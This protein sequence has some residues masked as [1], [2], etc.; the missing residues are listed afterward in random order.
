MVA[1]GILS[2]SFSFSLILSHTLAYSL[3]LYP[4]GGEFNSTIDNQNQ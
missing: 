4:M 3:I 1:T 2:L